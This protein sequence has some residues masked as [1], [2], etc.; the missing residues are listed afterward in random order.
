MGHDNLEQ[1]E[2]WNGAPGQRWGA[3]QESLDRVWR[4]LGDAAIE[5]AAVLPGERLI[6]VGCGCGATALELATKVGLSGSI[7]GIDVSAPMLARA[8]ERART[9]GVANVE[10]VQADASTHAFAGSA[11]LVFSRAGVMFFGDRV[12]RVCKSASRSSGREAVSCSCVSAKERSIRGGPFR[13]RQP[14]PWLPPSNRR[15]HMNPVPSLSPMRLAC[16]PSSTIPASSA[17][18]ASPPTTI[19]C[20]ELTSISP[21]SLSSTRVPPRGL[22]PVRPTRSGRAFGRQSGS[23]WRDTLVEPGCRSAQPLG[24]CR[25]QTRRAVPGLAF[26]GRNLPSRQNFVWHREPFSG[27]C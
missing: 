18:S 5:R 22:W 4:P 17:R 25:Q 11:N 3:Y 1:L 20:S 26:E 14:R 27:V 19:S 24:S 16:G 23:P 12:R 10:F 13:S 6:D 8:R 15:Q 2:F 21:P 7:V 9:L